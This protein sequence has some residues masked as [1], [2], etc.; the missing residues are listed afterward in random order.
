MDD[1]SQILMRIH[2]GVTLA[3]DDILSGREQEG[4]TGMKTAL[5]EL[6]GFIA[7]VQEMEALSQ[8]QENIQ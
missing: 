3:T 2:N 8:Q 5:D 1:L 7:I 6:A 4:V